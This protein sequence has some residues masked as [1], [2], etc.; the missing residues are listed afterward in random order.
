M[1]SLIYRKYSWNRKI[2]YARFTGAVAISLSSASSLA[3]ACLYLSWPS[4]ARAAFA[5]ASSLYISDYLSYYLSL[6][7]AS[8]SSSSG[9]LLDGLSSPAATSSSSSGRSL[10][11]FSSPAAASSCSSGYPLNS[12]WSPSASSLYSSVICPVPVISISGAWGVAVLVESIGGL[13]SIVGRGRLARPAFRSTK[14]PRLD[15]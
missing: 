6:P 4:L 9:R 15:S 3:F 12:F 5:S 13:E 7:S 11:S 10:D 1:P 14:L 8:S 2:K